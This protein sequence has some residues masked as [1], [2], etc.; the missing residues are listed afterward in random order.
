MRHGSVSAG[1]VTS[2]C[3]TYA[4]IVLKLCNCIPF[5]ERIAYGVMMSDTSIRL[6]SDTR[7]RLRAEKNG[8]ESYDETITRLLDE[9]QS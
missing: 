3:G 8:G 5:S 1:I 6:T 4:P 9:V 7:D 2:S